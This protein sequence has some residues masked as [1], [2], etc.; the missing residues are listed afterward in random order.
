MCMYVC[1]DIPSIAAAAFG[2]GAF[3]CPPAF[4]GESGTLRFNP[5]ATTKS[6]VS[7]ACMCV[8]EG[9]RE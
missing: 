3:C 9:G 2:F 6:T 1:V 8:R 7:A 4:A 5:A